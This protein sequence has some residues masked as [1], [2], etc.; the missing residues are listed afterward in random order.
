MDNNSFNVCPLNLA[1][2]EVYAGRQ[3]GARVGESKSNAY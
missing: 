1:R 2:L 3:Y